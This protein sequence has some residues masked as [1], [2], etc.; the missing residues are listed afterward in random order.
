MC[1]KPSRPWEDYHTQALPPDF[2][3]A[4]ASQSPFLISPPNYNHLI[5]MAGAESDFPID[6]T[7]FQK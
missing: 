1:R 5:N 3:I 7:K 6:L 2:Y 4:T